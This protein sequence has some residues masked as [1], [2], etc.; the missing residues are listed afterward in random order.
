MLRFVLE[1]RHLKVHALYESIMV[2]SVQ[3]P[4]E[5]DSRT[6]G[7]IADL[8]A[9]RWIDVDHPLPEEPPPQC[10]RP[11]LDERDSGDDQRAPPLEELG[12]SGDGRLS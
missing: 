12:N 9:R 2:N 4:V 8:D 7:A 11:R 1:F 5:P 3:G 10:E 6:E